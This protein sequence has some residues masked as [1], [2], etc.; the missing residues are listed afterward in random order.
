MPITFTDARLREISRVGGDLSVAAALADEVLKLRR[1]PPL[2]IVYTNWRGE[3][4]ER[5]IIP[6]Q[7]WYGTTE[8]HPA[9]QWMIKAFDVQLGMVRDFAW[10]GID[11][12]GK[13]Q[14]E[15]DAVASVKA[16]MQAT[17]L[18]CATWSDEALD[19]LAKLVVSVVGVG[20]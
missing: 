19:E 1:N 18:D 5:T 17:D 3:T 2:T 7:H 14:G 13:S 8:W 12:Q 16:A 20:G 10:A 4:E 11:F 6:I 15:A 9:P